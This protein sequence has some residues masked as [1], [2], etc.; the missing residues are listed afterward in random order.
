MCLKLSHRATVRTKQMC[1]RL[2]ETR[3]TQVAHSCLVRGKQASWPHPDPGASLT[4]CVSDGDRHTLD[5]DP[6][7]ADGL[8]GLGRSCQLGCIQADDAPSRGNLWQGA[9]FPE[10]CGRVLF[11]GPT[12]VGS[13]GHWAAT[14]GGRGGCSCCWGA[15][16][17]KDRL[18]LTGRRTDIDL[19]GARQEKVSS[20]ERMGSWHLSMQRYLPTQVRTGNATLSSQ[21]F[22]NYPNLHSYTVDIQ[23]KADGNPIY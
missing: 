22:S 12:Q 20:P 9:L 14:S 21:V 16:L 7:D 17:D 23:Q 8:H 11:A 1:F 6:I 5:L 2:G 15:V 18:H 3:Q 13:T 10:N 19:G 4:A